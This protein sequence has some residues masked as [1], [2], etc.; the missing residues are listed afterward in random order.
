MPTPND[1]ERLKR[2]AR[3]YGARDVLLATWKPR[4]ELSVSRLNHRTGRWERV[5]DPREVFK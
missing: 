2:V 3:R 4:R 5:D 1:A